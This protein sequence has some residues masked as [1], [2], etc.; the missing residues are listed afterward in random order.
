MTG[1]AFR[2]ALLLVWIGVPSAWGASTSP[3]GTW[4]TIDEDGH[5]TGTVQL[6]E[7]DSLLY[8]RIVA[9]DDPVKAHY[10]CRDCTDDRKNAPLLGL[11]FMRGLH[12]DGDHWDG[13]EILDPRTGQTYR[14][15]IRVIDGGEKLLVRG[16]L[17][18]SLFG[19]TQTWTRARGP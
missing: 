16:F 4:H 11:Q 10:V 9:I 8:G 13:G 15:T 1:S 6:W 17:G 12:E 18:I 2:L 5:A 14:C 7:Q 19:R 3:V